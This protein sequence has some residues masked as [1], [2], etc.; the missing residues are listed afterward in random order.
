MNHRGSS[1]RWLYPACKQE[2]TYYG[3]F[4]IEE[5]CS[6]FTPSIIIPS[7]GILVSTLDQTNASSLHYCTS[8]SVGGEVLHTLERDDFSQR[9]HRDSARVGPHGLENDRMDAFR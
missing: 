2:V 3:V 4:I 5:F 6:S 7:E 1:D 9:L 8:T